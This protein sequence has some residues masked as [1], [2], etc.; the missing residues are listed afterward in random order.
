MATLHMTRGDNAVFSTQ[1]TLGG[2]PFPIAGCTLVLTCQAPGI[3]KVFSS[4][5]AEVVF[6]DAPLGKASCPWAPSVTS[7]LSNAGNI[8][9]A[10]SWTLTDTFGNVTTTERFA[11]QVH[12]TI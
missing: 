2:F 8:T 7:G 5:L 1:V 10:C 11:I 12:P 3:R 4:D 6:T 9:F